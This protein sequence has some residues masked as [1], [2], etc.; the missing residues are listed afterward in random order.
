M[1][2]QLP[3]HLDTERRNAGGAQAEC[4]AEHNQENNAGALPTTPTVAQGAQ[5]IS[6]DNAHSLP[7][8]HGRGNKQQPLHD[9]VLDVPGGKSYHSVTAPGL[10]IWRKQTRH[11]CTGARA[12]GGNAHGVRHARGV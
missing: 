3:A 12:G 9:E 8:A 4:P 6:G 7:E 11:P 1:L 10:G 5:G 2:Q